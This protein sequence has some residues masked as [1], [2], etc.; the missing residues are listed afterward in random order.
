MKGAMGSGDMLLPNELQD[1]S[2]TSMFFISPALG[3]DFLGVH[4]L[5]ENH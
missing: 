5:S 1:I 2:G 4:L 3:T